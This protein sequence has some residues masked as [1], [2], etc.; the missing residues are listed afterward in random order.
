[1]APGEWADPI[2]AIDPRDLI[3]YLPYV[4]HMHAKFWG[5]SDDLEEGSIPYDSVVKALNEGGYDGYLSAEYE[6][7]RDLY[8]G[9]DQVRRLFAMIN[10]Q[11]ARNQ[12]RDPSTELMRMDTQDG[13]PDE[14]R[15]SG[16]AR[17]PS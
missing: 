8:A 13:V 2:L 1:M 15:Q 12:Q 16:A 14:I 5:V 9:N 6:G 17:L 4:F 11:T 7:P 3:P 10:R